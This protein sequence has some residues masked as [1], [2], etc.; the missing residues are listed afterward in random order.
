MGRE[1]KEGF[2]PFLPLLPPS[3]AYA[4][5]YYEE[6]ILLFRRSTKNSGESLWP[7]ARKPLPAVYSLIQKKNLNSSKFMNKIEAAASI[8]YFKQQPRLLIF[9]SN[10]S[11]GYYFF[12]F[13]DVKAL[14]DSSVLSVTATS[15][16]T[17]C[18]AEHNTV[19]VC[20]LCYFWLRQKKLTYYDL[21]NRQ[22]NNLDQ[23]A[24]LG[25]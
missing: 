9:I 15:Q 14:P 25:T 1:G 11:C 18:D 8:F 6:S 24:Y 21:L 12:S 23:A 19:L 22:K 13:T 2:P 3:P 4:W 16:L 5:Y 7:C 20:V 17:S 10:S